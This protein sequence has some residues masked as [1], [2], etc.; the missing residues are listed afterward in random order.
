MKCRWDKRS[1]HI[2]MGILEG[3]SWFVAKTWHQVLIHL[4]EPI[5]D[6]LVK[7][8]LQQED[9]LSGNSLDEQHLTK[10]NQASLLNGR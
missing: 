8:S 10:H 5:V 4:C 7:N 6:E 2:G 9:E 3:Q 1:Y